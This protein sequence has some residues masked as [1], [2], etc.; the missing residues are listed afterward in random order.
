MLPGNS[1]EGRGVTRLTPRGALLASGIGPRTSDLS[2]RVEEIL[3][4][5]FGE[6]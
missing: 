2:S 1:P 5:G 3:T 4:E 6:Q